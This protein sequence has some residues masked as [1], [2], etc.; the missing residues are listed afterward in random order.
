MLITLSIR[1]HSGNSAKIKGVVIKTRSCHYKI[2]TYVLKKLR[3]NFLG[4]RYCIIL[5][6]LKK[7]LESSPDNQT[8]D[9]I[10]VKHNQFTNNLCVI[11]FQGIPKD[12]FKLMVG[13]PTDGFPDQSIPVTFESFLKILAKRFLSSVPRR[14]KKMG[15]IK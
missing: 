9:Q 2:V 5:K 14:P 4:D 3:S 15:R 10:L 12:G 8:Y 11:P 13:G 1:D 7:E 6:G